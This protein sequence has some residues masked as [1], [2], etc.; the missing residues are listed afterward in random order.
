MFNC[1]LQHNPSQLTVKDLH[2]GFCSNS[3]SPLGPSTQLAFI[4][5]AILNFTPICFL[6]HFSQV[7][8]QLFFLLGGDCLG[9]WEQI[10]PPICSKSIFGA[11]FQFY[12]ARN[13]LQRY[14]WTTLTYSSERFPKHSTSKQA[15]QKF[16]DIVIPS[17]VQQAGYLF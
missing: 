4:F 15:K 13:L 12:G 5:S 7:N 10:F 11:S 17:S 8:F 1:L 3:A 16:E 6:Y 2:Q 9:A 14:H